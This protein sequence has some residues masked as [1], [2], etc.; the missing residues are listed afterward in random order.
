MS[1]K[2]F[3]SSHIFTIESE[4]HKLHLQLWGVTVRKRFSRVAEWS[5]WPCFL[6]VKDQNRSVQR[7]RQT[8]KDLLCARTQKIFRFG[9]DSFLL[10]FWGTFEMSVCVG[11]CVRWC[12][13]GWTLGPEDASEMSHVRST[14][15]YSNGEETTDSPMRGFLQFWDQL[16][17]FAATVRS[18]KT[19]RSQTV[20]QHWSFYSFER[21]PSTPNSCQHSCTCPL[22]TST[23]F[24]LVTL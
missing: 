3:I 22:P 8:L 12:L 18:R 23:M 15:G 24:T 17:S 10:L 6:H 13:F 2:V 4:T 9:S 11:L 5:T 20:W 16:C 7:S 14:H 1:T 21:P 19:Q